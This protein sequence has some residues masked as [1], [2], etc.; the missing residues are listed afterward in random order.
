MNTLRTL[1]TRVAFLAALFLTA[2]VLAQTTY[3]QPAAGVFAPG[4]NVIEKS[5]TASPDDAASFASAVAAAYN[6][7]AGGV[8]DLP[9]TVANGTTVYR[10]TY[11]ADNGRRLVLT[12]SVGM[13]N[14][15]S[16]GS[17]APVSGGNATTSSADRSSYELRIG[18]VLDADTDLPVA[19][20]VTRIGLPIL[21]RTHATYPCD[22]RVTAFFS[23][24][25]TSTALA[26][27]GNPK[28][29]DDTFYGFTAPETHAITNLLLES[30]VTDTSTP[31]STRIGW[32]DFGFITGPSF[33]P[34]PPAIHSINPPAYAIHPAASGV[35]FQVQSSVALDPN[36]ISL[37]L[38][39]NDVSAQLVVGG[40][41]TNRSFAFSGLL[42]DQEYT[43][44]INA[45]NAGGVST[46]TRIFYTA[47][48]S[49]T[50]YDSEGFSD[51]VLYPF[52]ALQAVTHG[53]ATWTPSATEPSEIVDAGAPQ[54]KVLERLNTGIARADVLD[55]PPLSS[56]T[57]I[58]EF[59]AWVSTTT[60]GRTI[61]VALLP[62]GSGN[63][64][65]FISWG[66]VPDQPEKL[67]YYD[68]VNWLPLADLLPD[69]HHC[70]IINYLSGPAAGHYDV[71]IND[72]A[73]GVRIPWRNATVG[74]VFGRLRYRSE[75][76]GP[77]LEYGR[78]DNL[79][80]TAAQEDTTA[81]LRPA[82]L[83]V[84]PAN[85]AIIRPEDG[86]S[87]EVT[88]GGAISAS[89][90]TLL[91]DGAPVT[92]DVSGT[93]NHLLAAYTQTLA[94]GNHSVEIHAT[95]AV[96]TASATLTFIATDEAWLVDPADGWAGPWQWSSGQAEFRTQ[97]PIDGAGPYLRLDT[98]GGS[99]NFMRQ[100]ASGTNVD[101]TKPHYLRWKFRLAEDDFASFFTLFNDRVQFFGRN[102]PRL[103]ASTDN[104]VNWSI[105]A[106]GNEQTA[107]SGI[108]AG[109]TFWIF[110]NVD[111]TGNLNLGNYLNT[112]VPLVPHQI[113]SFD[114]RVDPELLRYSVAITNETSGAWFKSA[115]PHRYR[116]LGVPGAD[117]TY[118]HFG[119]QG[120][121][122]DDIRPFDL[123]SVTITQ[124]TLPA[125]LFN[126]QHSGTAFS[127]SFSSQSSVI[128][129]AEY[130]TELP[131]A[132]WHLL[133]TIPGDGSDKTVTDS[134][135]SGQ[136]RYYRVRA[137]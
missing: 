80:L 39:D 49:F 123:D 43:M 47:T 26:N 16:T 10:G 131:P 9:T 77:V 113:Y 107:G 33:V 76:V 59:D 104:H 18:P 1:I 102:A 119:V 98:T 13:Q 136:Q 41:A 137:Q 20:V 60:L 96:G 121:P 135:L 8:F 29:T 22:I 57:L 112:Q 126:P 12:A 7:N 75:N 51:D 130:A 125:D 50:L 103:A 106:T 110:D 28:G 53:R 40:E 19:E 105:M 25:S 90:V 117:H 46:E 35:Q 133:D 68:N 48:G 14:V 65:S 34:P 30:F 66:G 122:A 116:N 128:Y 63:M 79:V 31:V 64:A 84:T 92:L 24:G 61:D 32:D 69:W 93:P 108:S 83:N 72:T 87:F 67:A 5:A 115:A 114:V 73:V 70:K 88:S 6:T 55:F 89:D 71:L 38:N 82:I 86:I 85:Q 101:I 37:V 111:G 127:F 58:I 17:L 56:G 109:Q 78:I 21:A 62:V 129:I 118:V 124:A 120:S 11:G 2:S 42:P 132:Q 99:R 23:D 134:N 3:N 54:G 94:A 4:P 81:F 52:G 36:D 44:T 100:Y 74:S 97:S 91:L 27:V 15:G 45:T 95:N